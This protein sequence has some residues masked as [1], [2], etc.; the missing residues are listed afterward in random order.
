MAGFAMAS[1]EAASAD[2][3]PPAAVFLRGGERPF[4]VVAE[5]GT[6]GT[7]GAGLEGR[8]QGR[9]P[10]RFLPEVLLTEWTEAASELSGTWRDW[11]KL[12][13]VDD[14]GRVRVME[15]MS[16]ESEAMPVGDSTKGSSE[17]AGASGAD[18]VRSCRVEGCCCCCC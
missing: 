5:R 3:S 12:G 11:P 16:W 18:R 4:D 9:P 8:R 17:A 15:G 13:V 14:G 2:A 7:A 6:A 10:V 1:P